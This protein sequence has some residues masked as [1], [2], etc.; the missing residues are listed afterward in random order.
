MQEVRSGISH[1]TCVSN[2][3]PKPDRFLMGHMCRGPL[4][5]SGDSGR[6]ARCGRSSLGD[7]VSATGCD[8]RER[9]RHAEA[10]EGVLIHESEF[11]QSKAVIVEGRAGVLLID[12]GVR[13]DEMTCL[14][15]DLSDSGQTVVTGF[16]P[17][18][19]WDHLLWHTDLGEAPRYGT[20]RCAADIRGVLSQADWKT[21]VAQVLPP[22]IAEQLPLDLLGLVTGLPAGAARIPWGGPRCG[23]SSIRLMPRGTRRC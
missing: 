7:P 10:A 1:T 16:S 19:H 6:G 4:R 2:A 11:I 23:S 8:H 9:E 15:N 14:A 3:W 13:D 20:A 5:T 22:D 18:P 21:Q 12:P 17:H